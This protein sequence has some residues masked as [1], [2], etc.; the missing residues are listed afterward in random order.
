MFMFPLKNLARKGLTKIILEKKVGHNSD[1]AFPPY[2]TPSH[3]TTRKSEK[4]KNPFISEKCLVICQPNN[5]D[6]LAFQDKGSSP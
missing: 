4:K 2:P 6:N 5:T 1:N 3:P